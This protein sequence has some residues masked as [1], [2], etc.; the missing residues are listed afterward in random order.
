[1]NAMPATFEELL[2]EYSRRAE[3]YLEAIRS[4]PPEQ[5]SHV[6]LRSQL[7][8]Y[9]CSKFMLEPGECD[10]EVLAELSAASIA[11]VVK[12]P[13]G[14]LAKQDLSMNCAGVSSVET[15]KILLLIALQ[16][17]LGIQIDPDLAPEIRTMDD[18]AALVKN[19][20]EQ[21]QV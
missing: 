6:F 20:P 9:V 19:A 21:Q 14:Q 17:A 4:C 3:T 8:G 7:Q 10:S 13:K 16:R 18:L 5:R 11:K 2:Q 1:M 12:L 15:K